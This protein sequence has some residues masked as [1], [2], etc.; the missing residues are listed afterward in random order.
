MNQT[1][2]LQQVIY[3]WKKIEIIKKQYDGE[4]GCDQGIARGLEPTLSVTSRVS[5]ASDVINAANMVSTLC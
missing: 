3:L 5:L 2:K 1:D 4:K